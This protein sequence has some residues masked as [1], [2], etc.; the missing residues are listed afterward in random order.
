MDLGSTANTGYLE[1]ASWRRKN[2]SAW[3]SDVSLANGG[4]IGA[5]FG[6]G[7]SF[8]INIK[9]PNIE[10]TPQR[11]PMSFHVPFKNKHERGTLPQALRV[12]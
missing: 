8:R 10:N 3:N 1:L 12:K 7:P 6:P 4:H 2:C 11:L 5:L 9:L